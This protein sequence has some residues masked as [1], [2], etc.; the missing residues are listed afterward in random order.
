MTGLLIKIFIKDYQN[1][2]DSK[3]RTAYGVMASIVGILAN[4]LLFMAKLILGTLLNSIS[5]T[6][7][8]FNNL[9]DAG[10]SIISLIG[11]KIA[12]KPADKEHPFGHGRVEY[13]AALIVSLIIIQVGFTF[14]RE[15]IDKILNPQEI[16]FKIVSMLILM[17]S[18][19]VKLWLGAFNKKVGKKIQSKI[20]MATATD[21]LSDVFVTGATIV[22]IL[23]F[24]FTG[25]NI[26]GVIGLVVSIVVMWAGVQ[27][28]KG[29]LEPLI[30]A[31]A[32]EK[33]YE[34]IT[35]L[36][37]SYANVLG[38]HDLIVHNYG[39]RHSMATIHVEV[40]KD[41]DV[42]I[43]HELIDKIERE[44]A[45]KLDIFLVIHMDPIEIGNKELMETK[46]QIDK[47]IKEFDSGLRSHD[48]RMVKKEN[49]RINLFFDLV[50]TFEYDNEKI[51]NLKVEV[52]EKI[53]Q[54]NNRI[55]CIV[56]VDK[57]YVEMR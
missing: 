1:I 40:C 52:V 57:G 53:Q 16:S 44:V 42:T 37:E 24:Y 51:N 9:S 21:S 17:L 56:T 46:K 50:V 11:V 49:N 41:V 13:I 3:V 19:V 7:D 28:A 5:V 34:N 2:E 23:I 39:P 47:I 25:I 32:D 54:Y 31:P 43:S 36:V 4:I 29:T 10:S 38:S 55:D 26:D 45:R 35:N 20:I 27:I 48:I 12:A 33:L 22:S 8:A 15:A 6:V 30:G 18:I 14:F